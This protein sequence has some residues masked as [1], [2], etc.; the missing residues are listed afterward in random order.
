MP[1]PQPRRYARKAFIALALVACAAWLV[2][3]FIS[4]ERYRRRLE[5]GLE[6]AL[7]RQVT[8]GA[9]KFRLVP[10]PGFSIERASVHEDPAFG[11]EP[12]AR[13]ERID[14]E[15]RWRSLWRPGI[16]FARLYLDHPT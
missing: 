11:S 1:A 14:C 15:L 13:V 16:E 12:F 5:A 3:S 6:Q 7:E 9:V 4:A 2:P 10:R 8:F